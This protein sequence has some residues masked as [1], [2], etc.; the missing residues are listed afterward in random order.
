MN[1]RTNSNNYIPFHTKLEN[2]AKVEPFY[3]PSASVYW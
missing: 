2:I 3:L 1:Q